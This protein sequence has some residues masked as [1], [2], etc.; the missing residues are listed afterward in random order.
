MEQAEPLSIEGER[1]R[2]EQIRRNQAVIDLLNSW[3]NND[4]EEQRETWM[5]LRQSLDE[6][7]VPL[8]PTHVDNRHIV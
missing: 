2:E 3:E 4:P 5:I 7:S 6:D 1:Q 8:S